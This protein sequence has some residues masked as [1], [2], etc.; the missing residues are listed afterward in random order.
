MAQF[1]PVQGLIYTS[2]SHT[3]S[4]WKHH[5]DQIVHTSTY[6]GMSRPTLSETATTREPSTDSNLSETLKN[7]LKVTGQTPREFTYH[8]QEL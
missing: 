4:L 8:G 2:Q 6:P 1:M 5:S 3:R 7:F